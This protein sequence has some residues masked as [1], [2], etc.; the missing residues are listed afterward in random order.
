[1]DKRTLTALE[2][3]IEKWRAIV[4]GNGV[5]GGA[6]NCPL[7]AAFVNEEDP[8]ETEPGEDSGCFGCPVAEAAGMT[9]CINTPYDEWSEYQS[10]NNRFVGDGDR[11]VFD[12]PSAVLAKNEL[13]FLLGL[14]PHNQEPYDAASNASQQES[15]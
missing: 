13:D 5:D 4:N 14:L 2:G 15:K 9:G 3:S 11:K 7:C 12:T 6:G 10:N 8:E 1:M